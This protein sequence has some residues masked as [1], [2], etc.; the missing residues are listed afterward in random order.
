VRQGQRDD[1][2]RARVRRRDQGYTYPVA[3]YDH[4]DGKAIAGG[5]VYRGSRV[6]ALVG[7]YLFGDIVSGRVFH[8]P[9]ADLRL[10]SQATIKSSP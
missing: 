3:Q 10:G 9:V 1:P 4:S 5:F 8:V 2:L 6:P 7:H